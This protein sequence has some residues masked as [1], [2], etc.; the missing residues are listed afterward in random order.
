MK[1]RTVYHLV[2]STRRLIRIL[3]AAGFTVTPPN[4]IEPLA[5]FKSEP[6]EDKIS[7]EFALPGGEWAERATEKKEVETARTGQYL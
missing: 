7:L 2:F 6:V 4:D 1:T 5:R 3:E